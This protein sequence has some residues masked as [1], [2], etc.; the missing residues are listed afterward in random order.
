MLKS[1]L[2]SQKWLS[3]QFDRLFPEKFRL[4][5]Q[6]DYQKNIV[7]AYLKEN[8]FVYDIGGGKRPYLN[9]GEKKRYKAEVIGLDISAEELNSAPEGAYDQKIT[10][11]IACYRGAGNAD[12]IICQSL[13]EHVHDIEAALAA[14][15]SILK[16]GGL[17]L[18]FVPSRNALYARLNMLLPQV[19]KKKLLFTFFP[20]SKVKLGF[21]AYYQKCT[22]RALKKVSADC[23]FSVIDVSYYYNSVYFRFFFPFQLL[24]RTWLLLYFAIYREQAAETFTLVLKKNSIIPAIV[25]QDA[26]DR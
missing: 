26:T 14:F 25:A 9:P 21:P 8:L 10:A 15:Q 4:D 5:G 11:D 16:P 20:E 13:L 7:P 2:K 24:W 3:K 12:L 19:V 6:T 18:V 23:N 22:P 1:F 17:A